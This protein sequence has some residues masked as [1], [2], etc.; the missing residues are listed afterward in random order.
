MKKIG[1]WMVLNNEMSFLPD[2]IDYHLS[3]I[4]KLYFLDTGSTD[5]SLEYLKFRAETNKRII[6]EE[7]PIKYKTKYELN[8]F[9]MEDPF[10][11]VIVRNHAIHQ[12]SKLDCDYWVQVDGD[13]VMLSSARSI[14]EN[15]THAAC[16]AHSTINPVC[17]LGDHP[18]ENRRGLF[19][20]DPHCRIWKPDPEIF[21]MEN[22]AFAGHQYHCIPS[23]KKQ[24]LYHHPLVEFTDEIFHFHLHWMYGSK[25]EIF[26]NK[27]NI[28]DK[29][30]M[31]SN[32]KLNE[33][34]ALLPQIF[35]QRQ[36][37]W[38]EK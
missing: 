13:E 10:P 21:Y 29:K 22:P 11:E 15:N 34:S 17:S 20:H 7:Y 23:Y 36:K 32:Q 24:H 25:L 19:L 30:I 5:G 27:E 18:I 1:L 16:I 26:Y 8:W 35:W 3:W 6:V 31:I 14:I 37:E 4:D 12:F 28:Y 9:E 2:I 33:Y 38:L